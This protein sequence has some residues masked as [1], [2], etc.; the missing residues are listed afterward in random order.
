MN[1]KLLLYYL[2]KKTV[3]IFDN[4]YFNLSDLIYWTESAPIYTVVYTL[5]F[6]EYENNFQWLSGFVI[7]L[8]QPKRSETVLQPSF[9]DLSA[10]SNLC[11]TWEDFGSKV[12]LWGNNLQNKNT[13]KPQE[14]SFISKLILLYCTTVLNI[15]SSL[16]HF[17]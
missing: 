9:R 4:S 17:I 11:K 5:F 14:D 3:C 12:V 6:H 10:C 2:R 13:T 16:Q 1:I 15:I 8:N 7:A